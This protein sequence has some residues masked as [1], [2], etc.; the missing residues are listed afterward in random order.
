MAMIQIDDALKRNIGGCKNA[1]LLL[2]IHDELGYFSSTNIIDHFS[3]TLLKWCVLGVVYECEDAVLENFLN[4][5]HHYM[6]T[7]FSECRVPL[8]VNLC[9]YFQGF[10][11][12]VV[13]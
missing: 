6:I 7:A 11:F 5:I 10:F 1:A 9:V 2:Q 12:K 13:I 3:L 8:G 4:L